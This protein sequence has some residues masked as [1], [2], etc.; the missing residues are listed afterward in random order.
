MRIILF[1]ISFIIMT[2]GVMTTPKISAAPYTSPPTL[3][4]TFFSFSGPNFAAIWQQKDGSWYC[5]AGQWLNAANYYNS[6]PKEL[7]NEPTSA[8]MMRNVSQIATR[9]RSDAEIVVCNKLFSENVV[10]ESW[11]V[12]RYRTSLTRPVYELTPIFTSVKVKL[13]DP[14]G[15]AVRV[16]FG[17]ACGK[18]VADYSK[19]S[20]VYSWREVTVN[21]QAG[22]SVCRKQ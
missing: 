13:K 20:K 6:L 9:D 7:P 10:I 21:N 11:I 3:D 22:I 16:P 19:T 1:T 2:I 8:Y 15:K 14:E 4:K 12:D 17:Q 5:F 18:K